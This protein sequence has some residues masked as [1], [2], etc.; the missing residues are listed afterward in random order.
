M[1]EANEGST[2]RRFQGSTV[3]VCSRTVASL[4]YE[5]AVGRYAGMVLK[6]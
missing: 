2:V 1:L 3:D 6:S 4:G 5:R